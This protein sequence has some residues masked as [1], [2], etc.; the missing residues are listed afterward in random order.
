MMPR[1]VWP[2][3]QSFTMTAPPENKAHR[4]SRWT[5]VVRH[6]LW[7]RRRPPRIGL[8]ESYR[9]V[10]NRRRTKGLLPISEACKGWKPEICIGPEGQRPDTRSLSYRGSCSSVRPLALPKHVRM[11]FRP[12]Q[13]SLMGNRPLVF[14]P[15]CVLRDNCLTPTVFDDEPKK[16]PPW[17]RFFGR[18][19]THSSMGAVQDTFSQ[20]RART[21]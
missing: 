20:S 14:E 15:Q 16:A 1:S 12:L 2:A 6:S 9:S 11:G 21:A 18:R 8:P 5:R 17:L 4:Q 3:S 13:A 10:S 19:A 7:C